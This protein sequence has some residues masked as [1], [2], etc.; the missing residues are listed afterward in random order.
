MECKNCRKTIEETIEDL[1]LMGS[2]SVW[3]HAKS[4]SKLCYPETVAE[5]GEE[6]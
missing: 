4:N 6:R 2:V 1:G 5:P 3:S